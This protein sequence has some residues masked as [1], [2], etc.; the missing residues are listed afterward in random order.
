VR[1]GVAKL[2]SKA[3]AVAKKKP[4]RSAARKLTRG[5]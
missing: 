5:R 4:L 1:R 2:K 3:K